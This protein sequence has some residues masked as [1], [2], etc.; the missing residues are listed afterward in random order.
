[1]ERAR[2]ERPRVETGD[3]TLR[4]KAA[5]IGASSL[6][7]CSPTHS[8]FNMIP[9]IPPEIIRHILSLIPGP[10]DG[11]RPKTLKA[12]SL[13]NH[14]WRE[15]AQEE[16]PRYISW[17]EMWPGRLES[18]LASPSAIEGWKSETVSLNNPGA[19][20]LAVLLHRA[21]SINHLTLANDD[22]EESIYSLSKRPVSPSGQHSTP[23]GWYGLVLTHPLPPPQH[24]RASRS[25][26]SESHSHSATS[27]RCTQF[28]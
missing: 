10:P 4:L 20:S 12:C 9:F 15:I 6:L 22:N 19:D 18:F 13:V 26:A 17:Y 3:P 5:Q 11:A 7:S 23:L 25:S 21:T 2:G 14:T 28:T 1:M 24:S 27:P 8:N 16:L